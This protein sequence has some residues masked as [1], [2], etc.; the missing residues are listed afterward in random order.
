V[1]DFQPKSG[2]RKLLP[3]HE[4]ETLEAKVLPK[5]RQWVRE[6]PEHSPLWVHGKHTLEYWGE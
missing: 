6:Y 3:A 4:R 5:A 1:S 2:D